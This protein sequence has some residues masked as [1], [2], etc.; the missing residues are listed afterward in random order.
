MTSKLI[1]SKVIRVTSRTNFYVDA[2]LQFDMNKFRGFA[3]DKAVHFYRMWFHLVRLIHE[4]EKNKIKIGGV[5][6]H[7]KRL[8]LKLNKRFYKDWEIDK[9]IDANFDDWFAD[10]IHLFAEEKV[11]LVKSA[12]ES[13]EHLYLKFHRNMRKRDVMKQVRELV[14]DDRFKSQSKYAIKNQYKYFY[15]HQ[16]YNVLVMRI[17]G[18]SAMQIADFIKST[19]GKHSEKVST[20]YSSLR[21]L[22]RASESLLINVSKG[23]Y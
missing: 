3:L 19:Y 21:R 11:T 10:K 7:S 14:K 15:L 13:D 8:T 9:Y 16:Q 23:Q 12:E 20:S 22:F 2:Q 4:C 6:H 5:H 18:M 1:H 17:N